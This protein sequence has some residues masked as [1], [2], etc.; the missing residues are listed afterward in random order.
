MT[1]GAPAA[2]AAAGCSRVG[3]TAADACDSGTGNESGAGAGPLG[4]ERTG[5][6]RIG[7]EIG[8][9][10]I[11]VGVGT[12]IGAAATVLTAELGEVDGGLTTGIEMARD[13]RGTLSASSTGTVRA[14]G[15]V[16]ATVV[17]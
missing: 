14:T 11:G 10:R 4:V 17:A 3:P 8:A 6:W 7:G 5:V 13:S 2:T 15:A 9:G 1:A 12:M 16:R